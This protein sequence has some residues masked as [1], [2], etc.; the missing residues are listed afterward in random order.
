MNQT[1]YYTCGNCG[2]VYSVSL[3]YRQGVKALANAGNEV[4]HCPFCG[5][6]GVISTDETGVIALTE[7]EREAR[8][9]RV[10]ESAKEGF[11]S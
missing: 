4:P 2:A 9:K 10:D 11:R 3:R 6:G 5:S 7:E 8:R 1:Q